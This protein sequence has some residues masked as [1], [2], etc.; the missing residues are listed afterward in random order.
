MKVK[1]FLLKTISA[2]LLI[3]VV[4]MIFFG[5]KKDEDTPLEFSTLST[6]LLDFDSAVRPFLSTLELK[7]QES[8]NAEILTSS[9]SSIKTISYEM[10]ESFKAFGNYLSEIESES[11][12]GTTIERTS[13]KITIKTPEVEFVAQL[14][15][16][17]SCMS[18][19]ST[20][21]DE[22]NIIEV[23]KRTDGGYYAQLVTKTKGIDSYVVYQL[24]FLGTA[25]KFNLDMASANYISI[26]KAE[27]SPNVFPNVTANIFEN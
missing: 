21:A 1:N 25:G 15:Q 10:G 5:C 7:Y 12:D 20:S 19:T 11:V 16:E 18:V 3:A 9:V 22:S 6:F 27:I 2:L 17:K 8:E 26:Y 14:S 4:P 24:S 23:T 13:E